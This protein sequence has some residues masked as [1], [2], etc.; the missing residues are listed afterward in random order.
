MKPNPPLP[1]RKVVDFFVG[2][3]HCDENRKLRSTEVH[4][5]CCDGSKSQPQ[6][7]PPLPGQEPAGVAGSDPL[8]HPAGLIQSITEPSLCAYEMIVCVPSL[9]A[10]EKPKAPGL[11]GA[12]S[13]PPSATLVEVLGSL[14]RGACLLRQEEWWTYEVHFYLHLHPHPHPHPSLN[15][16]L[17]LK[18]T[19]TIAFVFACGLAGVLWQEGA[20]V[21]PSR[22]EHAR[23]ERRAGAEPGT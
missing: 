5:Q 14:V 3:Q 8:P 2:G 4:L 12:V 10:P 16:P 21:S 20:A 23:G 9:C 1:S 18:L 15:L 13:A 7:S 6:A 11:A 17:A 22:G 19:P